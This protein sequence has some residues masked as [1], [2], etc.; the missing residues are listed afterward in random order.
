MGADI[1][2]VI[3][4]ICEKLGTTTEF[5]IPELA[6]REICTNVATLLISLIFIIIAL[7][8][9]PKAWKYDCDNRDSA[10]TVIPFLVI[11]GS[12]ILLIISVIDL[13][14]WVASPTASS[15]IEIIKIVGKI[16]N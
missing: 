16:T 1:N 14:G 9:L 4:N 15:V 11:S 2:A 7:Y 13:V 3:D 5:L 8:F 10:M 12:C 6:R